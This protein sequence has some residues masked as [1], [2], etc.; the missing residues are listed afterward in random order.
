MLSAMSSDQ[1]LPPGAARMHSQGKLSFRRRVPEVTEAEA[2]AL[3][4]EFDAAVAA[5]TPLNTLPAHHDMR[6]T[7]A[8]ATEEDTP[9]D[10]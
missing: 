9:T 5:S 2:A 8:D 4:D 7:S 1:V 10:S 6:E 3:A